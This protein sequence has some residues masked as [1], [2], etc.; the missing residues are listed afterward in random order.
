M[1]SRSCFCSAANTTPCFPTACFSSIFHICYHKL[2]LLHIVKPIMAKIY[3]SVWFE[4]VLLSKLHLHLS[5]CFFTCFARAKRSWAAAAAAAQSTRNERTN[6]QTHLELSSSAEIQIRRTSIYV[7]C[8]CAS[9]YWKSR[10]TQPL[11]ETLPA[12]V[13]TMKR[14]TAAWGIPLHEREMQCKH[15]SKLVQLT[16]HIFFRIY[17]L[18]Y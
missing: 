3:G 18:T 2:L 1:K 6:D 17:G 11:R 13:C 7:A 9:A 8:A 16:K 5:T 14:Y 10:I 12:N 4:L 15:R